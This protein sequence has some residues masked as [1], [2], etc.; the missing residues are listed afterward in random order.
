MKLEEYKE[1]FEIRLEGV[2][3]KS[4]QNGIAKPERGARESI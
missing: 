1:I 4:E 2:Q 3:R